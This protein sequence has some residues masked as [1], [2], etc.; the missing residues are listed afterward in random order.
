MV[1]KKII[2]CLDNLVTGNYL[3]V[4]SKVVKMDYGKEDKRL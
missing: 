3:I 1:R 4:F 2:K